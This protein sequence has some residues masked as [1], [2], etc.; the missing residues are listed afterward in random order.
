MDYSFSIG[1]NR[2]SYATMIASITMYRRLT[3][4]ELRNTSIVA[5][6]SILYTTCWQDHDICIALVR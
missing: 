4:E 6:R 1:L 5:N 2:R 3:G